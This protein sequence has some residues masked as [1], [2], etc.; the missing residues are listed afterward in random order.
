MWVIETVLTCSINIAKHT[1]P[2]FYDQ[3]V[4]QE[5]PSVIKQ[6]LSGLTALVNKHGGQQNALDYLFSLPKGDGIPERFGRTQTLSCSSL[7]Y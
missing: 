2:F 1:A 7:K 4:T 5:S 6:I 3:L